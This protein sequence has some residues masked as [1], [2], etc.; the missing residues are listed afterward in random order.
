MCVKLSLEEFQDDLDVVDILEDC[1]KTSG[2]DAAT[3]Q[4]AMA[5]TLDE[6]PEWVEW[7]EE[8]DLSMSAL[9][10][11][12][13]PHYFRNCHRRQLGTM[14]AH[15]DAAAEAA[16]SHRADHRGYQPAGDDVV[17]VVKDRMASVE[18]SQVI[19]MLPAADLGRIH[20]LPHAATWDPPA[21]SIV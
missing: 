6:D 4:A 21:E 8:V 17:L 9:T 18:V 13:A 12:A 20:G 11:P 14:S 19:L 15:G 3:R 16:A 2:L 1:L 5:Y 7:A 10:G